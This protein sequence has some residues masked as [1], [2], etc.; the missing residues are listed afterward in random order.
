MRARSAFGV[1]LQIAAALCALTSSPSAVAQTP[2]PTQDGA[3]SGSY[4]APPWGQVPPPAWGTYSSSIGRG[5]W[6]YNRTLQPTEPTGGIADG[7][8]PSGAFSN[9]ATGGGLFHPA[10]TRLKGRDRP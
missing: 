4:A 9:P 10:D 3:F 1:K 6:N 2:A 8:L 7:N 5:G